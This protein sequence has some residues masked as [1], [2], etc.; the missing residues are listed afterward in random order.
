MV[1]VV[2]SDWGR[3][4]RER[5]G[6]WI[7]GGCMESPSLVS[8]GWRSRFPTNHRRDGD[9]VGRSRCCFKSPGEHFGQV[10]MA[11]P[12]RYERDWV[13]AKGRCEVESGECPRGRLSLPGGESA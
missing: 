9:P 1:L 8:I 2:Q 6:C 3:Q 13:W 7:S 4:R 12:E 10:T 11:A 5:L